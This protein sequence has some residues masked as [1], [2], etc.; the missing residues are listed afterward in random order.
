MSD[1]V[2]PW[3]TVTHL[4]RAWPKMWGSRWNRVALLSVQKLFPLPACIAAILSSD[5]GRCWV[6]VGCTKSRPGVVENVTVT[7]E[8]MLASLFVWL[9]T[10]CASDS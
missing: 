4:S 6:M 9:N 7:V 1:D 5:V 10:F 2:G 3:S 8:I